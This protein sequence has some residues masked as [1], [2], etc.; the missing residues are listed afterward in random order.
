V[1]AP[2]PG[3]TGRDGSRSWGELAMVALVAV[4]GIALLVDTRRIRIPGST[5]TVGPR[6]FPYLVGA[7]L[8]LVALVLG[9][10]VWRGNRAP[11]DDSEDVDTTAGTSWTAVGLVALAF[12]G[13][14]LLINVV[15]WPLAVT[16]MFAA[17]AKVLGAPGWVRPL[18]VGGALSVLTWLV[19]VKLLD[20]ALP[21][22][23]LLEAVTGG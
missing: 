4:I 13:H 8:V 14:A 2:A 9:A 10:A 3:R 12:G 22:G 6:F 11:A 23:T 20:V 17:V 18:L 1:S 7:A 21:G 19:F 16:L 15:G 5:N